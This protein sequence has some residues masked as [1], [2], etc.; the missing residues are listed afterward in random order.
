MCFVMCIASYS[1]FREIPSHPSSYKHRFS[2][3]HL[4]KEN[5]KMKMEFVLSEYFIKWK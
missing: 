2:T 4:N 5:C 1:E 3:I